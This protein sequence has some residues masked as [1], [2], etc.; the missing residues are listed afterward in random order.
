MSS[1]ATPISTQQLSTPLA[2]A[3]PAVTPGFEA[4]WAA[5]QARGA[6]HDRAFRRRLAI[7]APLVAVGAAVLYVLLVL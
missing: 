3:A 2:V 4:R 7:V 5:W 1:S 6:A